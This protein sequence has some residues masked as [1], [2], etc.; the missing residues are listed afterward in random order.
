MLTVHCWLFTVHFLLEFT[1]PMKR[2]FDIISSFYTPSD[3]PGLFHSRSLAVLKLWMISFPVAS[4]L[5][6]QSTITEK[7]GSE[8]SPFRGK[9]NKMIHC[10][11]PLLSTAMGSCQ[12]STDLTM[13]I[14][15][16]TATAA[17]LQSEW[18]CCRSTN[19]LPLPLE[20]LTKNTL[21]CG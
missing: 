7:I 21:A 4:V 5:F 6:K 16:P 11:N 19:P 9:S 2:G 14:V 3:L 10:S 12:L 8:A 20:Q 15:F 13:P 18:Y 17:G 1:I